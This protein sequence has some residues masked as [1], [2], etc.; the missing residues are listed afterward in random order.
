M[1]RRRLITLMSLLLIATIS[2]SKFEN[3]E[4]L[5]WLN[6]RHNPFLDWTMKISSRIVELPYVLVFVLIAVI[7]DSIRTSLLA[8][9]SFAISGLTALYLKK[10]TF[11]D[12][13]RPYY[14][15][16]DSNFH[17]T[18]GI[19]LLTDYGI[20][21]G[22]TATAFGVFVLIGLISKN[23]IIWVLTI[24]MA[25]LVGMSRIY[26]FLHFY[27]DVVFGAWIGSIA[28][29]LLYLYLMPLMN[30]KIFDRRLLGG[31]TRVS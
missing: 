28:A 21:S 26:L 20:P 19:E 27:E 3:G 11:P 25:C 6:A 29:V 23:Q 30:G 24:S 17:F 5:F 13:H 14:Y 4:V 10:Y 1:T 12:Y 31:M 2:I 18:D 16:Q 9:L 8:I 7:V 22:H 15:Y